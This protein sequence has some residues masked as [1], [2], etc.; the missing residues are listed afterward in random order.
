LTPAAVIAVGVR[1]AERG[2]WRGAPD[3]VEAKTHAK[4]SLC[5]VD[6]S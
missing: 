4:T 5:N 3:G 2:G 6:Q 1:Q